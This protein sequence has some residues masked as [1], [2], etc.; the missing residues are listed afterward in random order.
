VTGSTSGYP[1]RRGFSPR[2]DL[3]ILEE[4]YP[5][6]AWR[7]TSRRYPETMHTRI[8]LACR[9]HELPTVVRA[10]MRRSA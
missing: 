6:V 9:A 3:G 7:Q 10:I 5:E 8:A 2:H 1:Q 4:R